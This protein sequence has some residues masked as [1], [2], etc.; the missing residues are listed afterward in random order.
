MDKNADDFLCHLTWN[1]V[2]FSLPVSH[3]KYRF[4]NISRRYTQISFRSF[5]LESMMDVSTPTLSG[6]S[7]KWSSPD[8]PS[9][10]PTA[11]RSP[12]TCFN[13]EAMWTLSF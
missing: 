1:V 2:N 12:S 7:K 8:R 6:N 5:Q 3:S 4:A 11:M 13:R 9:I 10:T